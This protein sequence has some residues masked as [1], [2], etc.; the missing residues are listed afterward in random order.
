MAPL[1]QDIQ[2]LNTFSQT[3]VKEL[4]RWQDAMNG[5]PRNLA[6]VEHIQRERANV[7]GAQL[8]GRLM[9]VFRELGKELSCRSACCQLVDVTEEHLHL[10]RTPIARSVQQRI[11]ECSPLLR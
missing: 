8:I 7:I 10:I 9:E 11:S 3:N 1:G 5:T 2:V 6:F 4:Q